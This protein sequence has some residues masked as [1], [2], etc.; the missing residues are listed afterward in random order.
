MATGLLLSSA[1]KRISI[2]HGRFFFFVKKHNKHFHETE[3]NIL[4]D[5]T[6]EFYNFIILGMLS[7]SGSFK[8]V[9]FKKKNV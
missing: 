9:Q 2:D 5:Q 7:C 6:T 1:M 3:I 8:T 4:N